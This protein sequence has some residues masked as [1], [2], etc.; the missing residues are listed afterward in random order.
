MDQKVK[1]IKN[2]SNEELLSLYSSILEHLSYLE[3]N[4]LSLEEGK[5]KEEVSTEGGDNNE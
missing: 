3:A 2:F 4:L 5:E 1:N